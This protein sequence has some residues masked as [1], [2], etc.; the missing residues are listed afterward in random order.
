M[1]FFDDNKN[2]GLLLLLLGFLT[3]VTGIVMAATHGNRSVVGGIVGAV[4]GIICGLLYLIA[5]YNI[6][7]SSDKI[8]GIIPLIGGIVGL[9]TIDYG[10]KISVFALVLMVFGVGEIVYALFN[11]IAFAILGF[12]VVAVIVLVLAILVGIFFIYVSTVISGDRKSSSG[13]TL[14]I[15]LLIFVILGIIQRI[16]SITGISTAHLIMTVL[17]AVCAIVIYIYLLFMTISPEV[18]TILDVK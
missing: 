15:I 3:I 9:K 8:K 6:R 17:T 4:G 1:P 18:K 2:V 5:G 12:A 13:N 11:A 10:N 14:W 7:E 16:L